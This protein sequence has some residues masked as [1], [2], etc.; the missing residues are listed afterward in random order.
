MTQKY[1]KQKGIDDL[2]RA[3]QEILGSDGKALNVTPGPAMGWADTDGD[4]DEVVE[5]DQKYWNAKWPEQENSSSKG[6]NGRQLLTD[7]K[8]SR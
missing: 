7:A 4:R 3:R 2:E 5:P 8:R 1:K 6:G